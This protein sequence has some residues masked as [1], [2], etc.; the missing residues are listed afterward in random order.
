MPTMQ[1]DPTPRPSPAPKK[2]GR[3]RKTPAAPSAPPTTTAPASPRAPIASTSTAVLPGSPAAAPVKP[4]QSKKRPRSDSV[5]GAR[6]AAHSTASGASSP[7]RPAPANKKRKLAPSKAAPP[8]AS[9]VVPSSDAAALSDVYPLFLDSLKR[10][11]PQAFAP[12]L[13]EPMLALLQ[14]FMEQFR[15]HGRDE[16]LDEQGVLFEVLQEVWR[17]GLGERLERLVAKAGEVVKAEQ[18]NVGTSRKGKEKAMTQ[19]DGMDVDEPE[20]PG[21]ERPQNDTQEQADGVQETAQAEAQARAEAD[22][23]AVRAKLEKK[24]AKRRR[25]ELKK[26]AEAAERARQAESD[27]VPGQKEASVG[28]ENGEDSDEASGPQ[29]SPQTSAA[30]AQ[31]VPPASAPRATTRTDASQQSSASGDKP[32][33]KRLGKK[34]KAELRAAALANSSAEPSRQSSPTGANVTADNEAQRVEQEPPVVD[35]P[36]SA[37]TVVPPVDTAVKQS[38]SQR[39][40]P[41]PSSSAY[42]PQPPSPSLRAPSSPAQRT[43]KESESQ[44]EEEDQRQRHPPPPSSE[45]ATAEEDAG[46]PDTED[47]GE[48]RMNGDMEVDEP[49]PK[50][51]N[52]E[53]AKASPSAL[54]RLGPALEINEQPPTPER[55]N[56]G[57]SPTSRKHSRSMSSAASSE[58]DPEELAL[59]LRIHASPARSREQPLPRSPLGQ[60]LA[61]AS[62]DPASSSPDVP[63]PPPAAQT[64]ASA[65]QSVRPEDVP[66]PPSPTG[67]EPDIAA[68]PPLRRLETIGGDDSDSDSSSDES[69]SESDDDDEYGN[70]PVKPSHPRRTSLHRVASDAFGKPQ[71]ARKPRSSLA[72]V[73][74]PLVN[75]SSQPDVEEE[76][77]FDQLLSQSQPRSRL[78]L[79]HVLPV[80]TEEKGVNGA[81]EDADDDDDD[82]ASSH[83]SPV[84]E[85][86][87]PTPRPAKHGLAHRKSRDSSEYPE[88]EPE[89][90]QEAASSL[91]TAEQAQSS[92]SDQPPQQAATSSAKLSAAQS[93]GRRLSDIASVSSSQAAEGPFDFDLSND[94]QS[95]DAFKPLRSAAQAEE[96]QFVGNQERDEMPLFN[97]ASQ[98]QEIEQPSANPL[99]SS[100]SEHGKASVC[101]TCADPSS[102]SQ[103]IL[104]PAH[105]RMGSVK[106]W[107]KPTRH[108]KLLSRRRLRMKGS[109]FVA[110]ALCD[111]VGN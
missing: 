102:T 91:P 9:A 39:D 44:R 42:M 96:S 60:T 68:P 49:M 40:P 107:I 30:P 80:D 33:R 62:E 23:S 59:S 93:A 20:Q 69:S 27:A 21:D 57:E 94:S 24:E 14:T 97:E 47:D 46:E 90:Q 19:Q 58:E 71:S 36:S 86:R 76:D 54:S 110:A 12:P 22:A 50:P 6:P 74:S 15:G 105:K 108:G 111:Q 17:K 104:V 72:K 55:E 56:P 31:N 29:E 37:A 52:G 100:Q 11:H 77:D 82:E 67:S 48:A 85:S 73:T 98:L 13:G 16:R 106:R 35:P 4:T 8:A 51:S 43:F 63:Q 95:Q 79:A 84:E 65:Q 109:R 78:S 87:E 99:E 34:E 103:S 38:E 26:Q 1:L 81:D 61:V 7:A 70:T 66:L 45:F 89:Q 32:R 18:A 10:A 64:P 2:R 5:A 53:A 92:S 101:C 75:K 83:F 88:S 25:R 3:P 41:P 28:K